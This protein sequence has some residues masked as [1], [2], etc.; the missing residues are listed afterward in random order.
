[1]ARQKMGRGKYYLDGMKSICVLPVTVNGRSIDRTAGPVWGK[2]PSCLRCVLSRH[3][4]ALSS[5]D[6]SIWTGRPVKSRQAGSLPHIRWD[7]I[8]NGDTEPDSRPDL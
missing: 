6:P 2:H 3:P 8:G 5:R 1:M 7:D 4:A